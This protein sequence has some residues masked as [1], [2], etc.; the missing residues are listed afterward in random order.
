MSSVDWDSDAT[1]TIEAPGA[2]GSVDGHH[3]ADSCPDGVELA[4]TTVALVS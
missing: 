3:V 4:D 1:D 2:R